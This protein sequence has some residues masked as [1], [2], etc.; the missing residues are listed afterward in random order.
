[1]STLSVETRDQKDGTVVVVLDGAA[2]LGGAETLERELTFLS[3]R[4]PPKVVFDLSKLTFISSMGIGVLVAF[5]RRVAGWKGTMQL[6]NATDNV[7][8]AL[9]RCR[10]DE[11]F[12]LIPPGKATSKT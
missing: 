3:A 2:G 4:K 11:L 7:A 8:T 1:M 12:V 5:Q 6:A 9:R 10:L